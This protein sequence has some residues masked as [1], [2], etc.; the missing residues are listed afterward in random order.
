MNV[1]EHK[2]YR[3]ILKEQIQNNSGKRGYLGELA[4]AASCQRSYLTL[5]IKGDTH[6][7]LDHAF[8]LTQFWSL[9]EPESDYFMDLVSFERTGS[10]SLRKRLTKRMEQLKKANRD[11]SQRYAQPSPQN[12]ESEMAYYSS[13]Y[14][15]AIHVIV[16]IPGYQSPQMIATRLELPLELVNES[17]STLRDHGFVK[18]QGGKWYLAKGNIHLPRHSLFNFLNHQN[19]RMRAVSDTRRASSEGMHY[20]AVQSISKADYEEIKKLLLK[21]V[22]QQRKIVTESKDEELAVLCCDWFTI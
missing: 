16:S 20:T 7:T 10:P 9:S 5:V 4:K 22:D 1:F 14:M 11:F 2:E 21:F 12:F 17:L 13:W 8:G 6:F 15:G 19:W 3:A 18:Q